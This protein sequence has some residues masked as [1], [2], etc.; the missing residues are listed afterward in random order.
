M[1]ESAGPNVM[2]LTDH[3]ETLSVIE[4]L[5]AERGV[6]PAVFGDAEAGSKQ[7]GNVQWNLLLIDLETRGNV[8]ALLRNIRRDLPELPIGIFGKRDSQPKGG[9]VLLRGCVEFFSHP[10]DPQDLDS[11]LGV[12]L[13]GRQ[14][15]AIARIVTENPRTEYKIVGTSESFVEVVRQARRVAPTSVPV[16][17]AGESGTGKELISYLIHYESARSHNTFVQINCAALSDTLLE[18]ELFGHERGAFTGACKLHKGR[19]EQSHGGTLLLDEI[20]ETSRKFQGELLRVLEQQDFKRLGG[21]ENICVNVR[22]VSTTNRD[23]TKE[24]RHQRFRKDLYYRIS[25]VMLTIP[26]LR[27]RREDI[28]GLVWHFVNVYCSESGRRI[29]RLDDEMLEFFNRY[30]WPGNVRQLRNVVRSALLF[31]EGPV[32]LL[33]ENSSIRAEL[34]QNQSPAP[35]TLRLRE[36][37]RLAIIEALRRTQLNQAKAA[38]LLGI[39]DRTLREK[40]RRYDQNGDLKQQIAAGEG[41]W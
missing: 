20:S 17:I 23:L 32:L 15:P 30:D 14:V 4:T 24:V 18:S 33:D 3:P 5:L 21:D 26:P 36:L 2:V 6:T 19:F 37:E 25:G 10:V 7:S 29:E 9:D 13:S 11:F 8:S 31:G 28:S 41:Q 35:P 39:T 40:I 16:L 22:I 12:V 27:T 38:C 34:E 1:R